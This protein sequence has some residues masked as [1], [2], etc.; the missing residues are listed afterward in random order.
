M[1][2]LILMNIKDVFTLLHKK[3]IEKHFLV[4]QWN[5]GIEPTYIYK[6]SGW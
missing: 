2:K 5:Q 3:K 6:I 4:P 1:T